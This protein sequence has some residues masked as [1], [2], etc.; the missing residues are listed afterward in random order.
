MPWNVVL[1]HYETAA[2]IPI[3]VFRNYICLE[4]ITGGYRLPESGLPPE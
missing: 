2:S 4:R 1:E 3:D